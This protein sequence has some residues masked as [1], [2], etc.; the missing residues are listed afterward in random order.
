MVH[1]APHRVAVLVYDG[2]TLLD[3]AGPAEV[4]K[5]AHRFGADYRIELR[6][7]TGA[8][9]TSNLGIR[10]TVDGPVAAEPAFDTAA[11]PAAPLARPP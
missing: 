3:V 10:I 8:D 5:E 2:V 4:F 9:V 11:R 7:P 1:A 6:S